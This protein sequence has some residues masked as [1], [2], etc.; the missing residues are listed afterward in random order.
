[1]SKTSLPSGVRQSGTR[2]SPQQQRNPPPHTVNL[3]PVFE[4]EDEAVVILESRW[5]RFAWRIPEAQGSDLS[6]NLLWR[7]RQ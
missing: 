2:P 5:K 7:K 3:R 6:G 1:M 4:I